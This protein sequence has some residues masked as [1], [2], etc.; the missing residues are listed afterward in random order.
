MEDGP[1]KPD[2]ANVNTALRQLGVEAAWMI[3]DTPDD[4]NAARAARVLPIGKVAPE[5]DRSTAIKKLRAAGVA[6][7]LSELEQLSEYLP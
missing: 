2:P 6:H 4:I 1:A 7:V 5:D 3:G